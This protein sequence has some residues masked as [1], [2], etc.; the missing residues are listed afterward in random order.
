MMTDKPFVIFV[1]LVAVVAGS[2]SLVDGSQSS[3]LSRSEPSI[4]IVLARF[5]EDTSWAL[6]PSKRH[7]AHIRIYNKGAVPI[8]DDVRNTASV[9][10]LP[11]VGQCIPCLIS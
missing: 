6:T 4:E 3:S 10:A 8:A 9:V 5:D 1:L 7:G 2:D 11:N